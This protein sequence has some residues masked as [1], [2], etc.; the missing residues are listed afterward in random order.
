[1]TEKKDKV[2]THTISIKD[3]QEDVEN[4]L[5]QALTS[6]LD[7]DLKITLKRAWISIIKHLVGSI[8]NR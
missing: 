4:T 7:K 6:I 8:I 5:L 3:Y 1:L 2:L